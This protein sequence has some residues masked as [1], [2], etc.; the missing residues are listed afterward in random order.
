MPVAPLRVR[1][2]EAVSWKGRG[3]P[4][5]SRVSASPS[6]IRSSAGSARTSET[7]SGSR[8]EISSS[9]RVKTSTSSPRLWTWIRMPSSLASTARGPPSFSTAAGTS[10]AEE[11]S[12]GRTG[13]P[14]SRVNPASA[15]A[16]P[17]RAACATGPV[18]ALNIAARRTVFAGRPAACAIA[19]SITESRAPWRTLPV[20][21]A[22]RNCCSSAVMRP[23]RTDTASRRAPADPLPASSL[24]A[25]RA[26][27]TSVS[28]SEASAAGS[29]RSASERQPTP[30][31]R[32]RRVPER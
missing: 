24:T 28:E 18:G 10:A 26:A 8:A 12:I 7:T 21:S 25:A 5:S 4:A 6:R 13:R 14:A 31:R 3:R 19:S 9:D 27:S 22:R 15:S 30:V 2:V 32:W 20:T 11:A 1:V 23:N 17:V 29:G 16:P